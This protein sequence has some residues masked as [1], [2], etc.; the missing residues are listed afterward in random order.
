MA[1]KQG[2]SNQRLHIFKDAEMDVQLMR[3]LS[4]MSSGGA[5]IGEC[6]IVAQMTQDGNIDSYAFA[7]HEVAQRVEKQAELSSQNQHRKSAKLHYLRASSYY[8]SAMTCLSPKNTRHRDNWAKSR[9]CFEKAGQ[10]FITPFEKCDI[11]FEDK[12]LPCYLLRPIS[13]NEKLPTLIVAT[14]G[15]GTAM[16]MY[17]WI[18]SAGLERHYNILLYEGPGNLSAYYLNKNFTYRE[19]CEASIS[20]VI[21]FL[22]SQSFVDMNKI[23][24]IGFSFGGYVA[25]RAAAF[26]KRIRALI[27]DSPLRDIHRMFTAIFPNW[28]FAAIP[29]QLFDFMIENLMSKADRSPLEVALMVGGIE[30]PYEFIEQTKLLNLDGLEKNIVCPTLALASEEE[31]EELINQAKQFYENIASVNKKLYIFSVDEGA[32]AHC[33]MNNFTLMSQVVYDWL[34]DVLV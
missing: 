7:W 30:K 11:P 29:S 4:S 31:G 2:R 18:G 12:I 22:S 21:D 24:L 8:R 34:D 20:K 32:G 6:L 25:A 28:V 27:L 5:E 17:F 19:D 10:L 15:E 3:T 16:E 9:E 14:G 13:T 33:Q 1:L 23:A 26:E